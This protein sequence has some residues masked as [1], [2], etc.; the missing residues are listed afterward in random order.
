MMMEFQVLQGEWMQVAPL[1]DHPHAEGLQRVTSTEVAE[2]ARRF[3]SFLARLGRL[4]AGVPIFRGH[5]DTNPEQYPD[6][7][8]YGWVMELEDRGTDGLW[9]RVKWT[10][11]GWKLVSGGAF[12]FI[13]P[14]WRAV[15]AGHAGAQKIY[16]PVALES[17][18]LTNTP[19]IEA[20]K[21]LSNEHLA[22]SLPSG[23]VAPRS[24]ID[25]D[26]PPRSA[27][28]D[29]PAQRDLAGT[30]LNLGNM[31]TMKTLIEI[32]ELKAEASADEICAAAETLSNTRQA[33]KEKAEGLAN[34]LAMAR[35][36][37]EEERAGRIDLVLENA[38]LGGRITMAEE[39]RWKMELG[40][41]FD[42]GVAALR[43]EKKAL[44]VESETRELGNEKGL[45][46]TEATRRSFITGFMM[47]KM[48]AGMSHGEA[49]N[50]A[51]TSHPQVFEKMRSGGSL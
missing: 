50:L 30:E 3:N 46:E 45:F 21:P 15:L 22:S 25:A 5:P 28:P 14:V 8:A 44:K 24:Q 35:K 16:R 31:K 43:V 4:F 12:K 9:G 41:D 23:V 19:N 18:G 49:W 20:M 48:A 6:T 13:S 10:E 40:Q 2:M 37:I 32:L 38:I 7:M 33:E 42:K 17:I 29:D 39:P 27:E 34:E 47:E 51:K 11:E 1:G 26:L 36:R